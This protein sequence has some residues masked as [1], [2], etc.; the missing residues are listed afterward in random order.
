MEFNPSDGSQRASFELLPE[1]LYDAEVIEAE[2]RTSQKGNQMIA[3][4]LQIPHPGGY[5]ARVWDFLVSV[6]AAVFKIR[7]FCDAADLDD[8]FKSGRLT[9][10]NC[11]G[12]K[13][14][15]R[16]G[17]EEGRDGFG[18]RNTVHEYIVAGGARPAG[19][20]T[21]AS[22]DTTATSAPAAVNDEEIPF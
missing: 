17:V 18:D 7:M 8:A 9:A 6:P 13:V 15:A 10:E 19:I 5:E 12:K 2:E 1:G 22:A 4:T 21:M 20:A 14:K 16:I 3:L 11:V